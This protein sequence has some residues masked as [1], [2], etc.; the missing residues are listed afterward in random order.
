MQG[1]VG[2][3]MV[4][5]GIVDEPWVSP[6][7]L[8]VHLGFALLLFG[9]IVWIGLSLWRGVSPTKFYS[10]AKSASGEQDS[11][12]LDLWHDSAGGDDGWLAR[13]VDL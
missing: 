2:W 12:A 5:S 10:K 6:I 4:Q 1:Y 7:R 13:W 3:W 11:A 9:L 8:T